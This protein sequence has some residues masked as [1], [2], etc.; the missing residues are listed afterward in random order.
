M[1]NTFNSFLLLAIE[2]SNDNIGGVESLLRIKLK[3]CCSFCFEKHVI[4]V[5]EVCVCVSEIIFHQFLACSRVAASHRL[6]VASSPR[7]QPIGQRRRLA[8]LCPIKIA[9]YGAT[10]RKNSVSTASLARQQYLT[11]LRKIGELQPSSILLSQLL[12]LLS[13]PLDAVRSEA[14]LTVDTR[15]TESLLN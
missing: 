12:L 1:S 7:M 15:N 5:L 10:S 4:Y 9:R 6:T 3:M 11:I 14:I 13:T 8:Q 2:I